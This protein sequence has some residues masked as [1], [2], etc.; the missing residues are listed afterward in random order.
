MATAG[1]AVPADARP[2]PDL[3]QDWL[4]APGAAMAGQGFDVSDRVTNAA[5]AAARRS[6]VGY[7][8]SR[9]SR[10]SGD[11][12]RI[13]RRPLPRLRAWAGSVGHKTLTL[14]ADARGRYRLIA[15]ADPLQ[16]VRERT[17]R[18]NCVASPRPL[19]ASGSL[20]P[21]NGPPEPPPPSPQ[22]SPAPPPHPPPSHPHTLLAAG[23]IASCDS[24]GDEATA[25]L[26]TDRPGATVAT[27]GDNV[28]GGAT[29]SDFRSCYDP[30][31]GAVRSR[32]RPAAGNHEYEDPGA[33]GYFSYFGDAAGPRGK[34]WYSYDLGA[35]HVV[36]LNS[37]CRE[38]GGCYN[39]SEQE[40]WLASDLA[41][42]PAKCTLAYWH[43]PL[44]TS[45]AESGRATNTVPLWE[46]LYAAGAEIVL[47]GHAHEYERF[48]PQRPGGA[49]DPRNGV[50]EF[51]VGTGGK[52]FSTFG[53][54]AA[55]SERRDN[56]T[57]G[58][59]SLTLDESGYD[60]RFLPAGGGGFTDAGSQ[61]CH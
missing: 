10:R 9:D 32:T 18:D 56:H 59:I 37:N 46:D 12:V 60:W 3:R 55:N 58:V 20:A 38:V 31:W 26:L 48:A 19:T 2:L 40:R 16:R 5:G 8:L 49:A 45:D 22:P 25:R 36:V 13:G 47:N 29:I 11:D 17:E 41:A 6:S 23:D 61:S 30:S 7:F 14:P 27:L 52:S 24:H 21:P 54:I 57:F 39:G 44:F 34:G 42:H 4:S 1:A 51:V 28:Y 53:P 50:R 33:A 43:D 15:C 35:W